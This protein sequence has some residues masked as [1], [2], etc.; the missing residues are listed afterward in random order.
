MNTVKSNAHY[1]TLGMKQGGGMVIIYANTP[2]E[3]RDKMFE[4]YG[5][6]WA[7]Q[8]DSLEKMHELD[9]R[10]VREIW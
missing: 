3:A 9:K 10:L 7:F 4:H 8:Y 5:S 2:K 1:F 6:K